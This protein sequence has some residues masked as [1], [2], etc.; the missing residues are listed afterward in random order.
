MSD[1]ATRLRP[2]EV[3]TTR[4]AYSLEFFPPRTPEGVEKLRAARRQLAQLEPAF[5]SVTFLSLIHI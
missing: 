4:R 5:C 1:D 2:G 3:P